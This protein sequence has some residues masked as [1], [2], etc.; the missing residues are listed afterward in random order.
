MSLSFQR[1]K[2]LV[3]LELTTERKFYAYSILA[4]AGILLTYMLYNAYYTTDGLHHDLQEQ[5]AT[6]GLIIFSLMTSAYYFRKINSNDSRLESLMLPVSP[7][8]RLIVA[9]FFTLVLYQIAYLVIYFFCAGTAFYVDETLQHG[10]RFYLFDG[11]REID[12]SFL[13]MLFGMVTLGLATG[14]TFR[15]LPVVKAILI[16]ALLFIANNMISQHLSRFLMKETQLP[17]KLQ[18][19]VL[20]QVAKKVELMNASPFGHWY[21]KSQTASGETVSVF[22]INPPA[23]VELLTSAAGFL[24]P[25]ALMYL[26]VLKLREQEI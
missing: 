2:Q 22:T 17:A 12:S 13:K 18:E 14:A 8:E 19:P 15:K 3:V 5:I 23:S 7:V 20:G 16:M 1:C 6:E 26:V 10:N 11:R 25:F 21:L 9:L 4:L 24:F